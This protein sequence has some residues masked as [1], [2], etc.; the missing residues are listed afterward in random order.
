MGD[1]TTPAFPVETP[2]SKI[3]SSKTQAGWISLA[4][5]P[6]EAGCEVKSSSDE[7]HVLL[8]TTHIKSPSLQE[9]ET[10]TIPASGAHTSHMD[11]TDGKGKFILT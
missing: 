1:V 6:R 10:C 7:S 11:A 4:H 9:S 5:A 3:S 8:H 2:Q